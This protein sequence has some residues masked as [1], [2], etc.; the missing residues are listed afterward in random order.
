MLPFDSA[1]FQL[2]HPFGWIVNANSSSHSSCRCALSRVPFKR[3][4]AASTKKLPA[5]ASVAGSGER[6][7]KEK[8]GTT[9]GALWRRLPTDRNTGGRSEFVGGGK[10]A[11]LVIG[12]HRAQAAQEIGVVATRL[13]RP[14][15]FGQCP[16]TGESHIED[17]FGTRHALAPQGAGDTE[18]VFVFKLLAASPSGIERVSL[19]ER[20]DGHAPVDFGKIAGRHGIVEITVFAR[21][22]HH[23]H[24]V[25]FGGFEG[26]G[27]QSVA[28]SEGDT[29]GL[30]F[31]EVGFIPEHGRFAELVA[32]MGDDAV[33]EVF[34]QAPILTA[35]ARGDAET[36]F[37]GVAR[38]VVRPTIKGRHPR[39]VTTE[40]YIGG[41]E[42]V[43]QLV[44][45]VE[46]EL[47]GEIAGRIE[48]FVGDAASG[49]NGYLLGSR[50][51][52][53][54]A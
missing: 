23:F 30:N 41:G 26:F 34:L 36:G 54:I 7:V 9:R 44:E 14:T 37:E 18:H 11:Q 49:A 35:V 50:G 19:L 47:V 6:V 45:D 43:G 10:S 3:H 2:F 29:A 8:K 16:S 28:P 25:A 15:G 24:V 40:V 12:H 32:Q 21:A 46:E 22:E 20:S 39:F 1:Y 52:F 31:L 5:T 48:Q 38:G 51:E 17:A 13:R 53:G 27:S 42:H 33:E 4:T